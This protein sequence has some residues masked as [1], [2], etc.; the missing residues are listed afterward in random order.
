MA[1][2]AAERQKTNQK[3]TNFETTTE[4]SCYFFIHQLDVC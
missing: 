3:N 4:M 2:A 1:E